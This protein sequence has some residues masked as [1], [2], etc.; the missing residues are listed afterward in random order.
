M[1]GIC[2]DHLN[3]IG[4]NSPSM[5]VPYRPYLL[6]E[7]PSDM[8]RSILLTLSHA[9]ISQDITNMALAY[10]GNNTVGVAGITADLR[11]YNIKTMGAATS[12][13]AKR[14][15]RFAEEVKNYQD[16]LLEYRDAVKSNPAARA[17]TEQKVHAAFQKMQKGFQNE[18]SA[19]NSRIHS[20]KGTVLGNSK[21]GV[22]I[23]RNSRNIAKLKVVDQ[24]Q[25]NNLVMLAKNGKY[26]GNGL[27]VIDFGNRVGNVKNSYTA[28][29]QWER[30]AFIESLSF[31]GIAG[32]GTVVVYAGDATLICLAA[33][34]P[35]GW[36]LI[37]V[38]LAI[39]GLAAGA[40]MLTGRTLKENG[41]AWYDAIMKWSNTL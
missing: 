20:H 37:V 39:A 6:G 31:A 38:G 11:K 12:V 4:C 1:L 17:V 29:D 21:R 8:D 10:G 35:P 14:M 30:E 28:G 34:T 24:V 3:D 32:A 26:L 27:T 25:A 13:Y 22:N 41:G 40:S 18:L 36:V 19:V 33:L 23:A 5:P 16:A 9:H 2:P 15:G 7:R